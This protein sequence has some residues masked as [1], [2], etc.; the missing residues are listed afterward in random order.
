MNN[1][2]DNNWMVL[3]TRSRWE[4][5]VD[6]LLKEQN[7]ISYCPLV[8][9]SKQ[10]ADRSKT[11]EVPLFNSYLFVRANYTDLEKITQT[12]GVINYI[13]F[14]GK[15]AIVQ[16]IEI[17]KIKR[18]V[19]NYRDIETTSLSNLQIGDEALIV[20]GPLNNQRGEVQKVN[21]KS[22]VMVIKSMNCALTVKIDQKGLVAC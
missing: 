3:Y 9:T 18:I 15:P 12:S 19:K 22:V 7:I 1:A 8:K 2:N 6:Q 20:D 11:V 14:C 17:E 16:D 10:W 4:K 5:K 21:G 13:T